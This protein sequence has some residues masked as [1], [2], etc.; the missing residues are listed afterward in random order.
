MLFSILIANYNNS[1]F[2][3]TAVNSIRSQ[4]YTQ[5]EIVL[6]DDGSTDEFEQVASVLATDR[7]IR[8]YRNEKNFGCGYTKR[9]CAE[10]A[11]GSIL[12][13]L[14]PDDTL[15]PDALQVMV[16]AHKEKPLHSII[17]STHYICDEQLHV[18]KI[19]GYPRALP[20]GTPY[21]FVSDGSVHQLASFKKECYEATEG[22]TPSNKKAVDQDLYYLLEETGPVHFINKPLY[23]YR[24]HAGSISNAGQEGKAMIAHFYV[25]EHACRRRIKQLTSSGTSEA[26]S[27]IRKYRTRYHK[28]R[29]LRSFREKK[30]FSFI[31]GIFLFPFVGGWP[32]I[33]SYF[34]KLPKEGYKLVRRS[35]V[36]T[37]EVK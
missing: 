7:R 8:I 22:L 18:K 29:I 17:Y 28:V 34:R 19:A 14:D 4:T 6:V 35:F 12:A 32:N 9:K 3:E 24:I 33:V 11:L 30:Y 26:A 13:F 21:L 10:N 36:D 37:Y 1:K 23:Y 5:W 31:T 25:I 15:T 2:L 27:M 20:E 16:D